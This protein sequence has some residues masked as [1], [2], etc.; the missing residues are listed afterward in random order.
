[1]RLWRL[2]L[3]HLS[4]LFPLEYCINTCFTAFSFIVI[5]VYMVCCFSEAT[6]AQFSLVFLA[7][8]VAL[9]FPEHLMMLCTIN[10][11]FGSTG[12]WRKEGWFKGAVPVISQKSRCAFFGVSLCQ[13]EVG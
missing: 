13:A 3:S 10:D 5:T 6:A 9:I 7:L 4:L 2:P 8:L 11:R 1:M 12:L